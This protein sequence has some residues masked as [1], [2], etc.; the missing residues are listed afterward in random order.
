[1][2]VD[3]EMTV[4]LRREI[5]DEEIRENSLLL[6]ECFGHEWF[7]LWEPKDIAIERTNAPGT[8][9]SEDDHN[10]CYSMPANVAGQ[11]ML[12]V[13]FSQR[14]YSVGYER[15]PYYVI[16]SVC[17]FLQTTWPDCE[18]W[19]AGDTG[20]EAERLDGDLDAKLWA[21]F[22]TVAHRPYERSW[23]PGGVRPPPTC[24][25]CQRALV[26]SGGGVD[27]GFAH[28]RS[29]ALSVETRDNGRTW[30]NREVMR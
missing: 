27:I 13:R 10:W 24:E 17:R 3:V 16:S 9:D 28:C 1:M 25:R 23:N 8:E 30:T 4:I 26:F 12:R 15:G 29:C 7:D 20:E 6:T 22:C 18:V 14:M 21:H 2:G 5:D 11:T 19:Y